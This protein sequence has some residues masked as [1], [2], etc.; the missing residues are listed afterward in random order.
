M[1]KCKRKKTHKHTQTHNKSVLWV[2]CRE[3][4][5]GISKHGP[6]K[7]AGDAVQRG[8]CLGVKNKTVLSC[9]VY[10]HA[11]LLPARSLAQYPHVAASFDEA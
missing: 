1:E 8:N 9:V 7:S 4:L 6:A 3:H 5:R 11:S 10:E 2:D